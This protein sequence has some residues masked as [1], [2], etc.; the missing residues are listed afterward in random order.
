MSINPIL[1]TRP[2]EAA[3]AAVDPLLRA[4][5]GSALLGISVPTF[6]RWVKNGILPKAVKLGRTSRWPESELLAVIEAAKNRRGG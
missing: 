6:W 5:E 4:S 3:K 1:P 2:P